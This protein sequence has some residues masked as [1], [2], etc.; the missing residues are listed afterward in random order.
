MC[1]MLVRKVFHVSHCSYMAWFTTPWFNSHS[2]A[3]QRGIQRGQV[4]KTRR[5]LYSDPD[6]G[7]WM[8]DGG[9]ASEI[10]LVATVNGISCLHGKDCE[11]RRADGLH[12]T[13]RLVYILGWCT[14][15]HVWKQLASNVKQR[16]TLFFFLEPVC[17]F[18]LISQTGE[19]VRFEL[20]TLISWFWR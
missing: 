8:C 13:G 2:N 19:K 3:D 4:L 18:I 11:R 1:T 15:V 10:Y 6:L 20:P 16:G 14:S 5:L 12:R 7:A 9:K 17:W